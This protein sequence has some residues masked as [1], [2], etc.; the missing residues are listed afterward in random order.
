M[1]SNSVDIANLRRTIGNLDQLRS[2]Q[3]DV[4]RDLSLL[5]NVEDQEEVLQELVL[6]ALENRTAFNGY[7]SVLDGLVRRVG[8][9]PYLD[10]NL[11]GTPDKIAYE[12]HRAPTEEEPESALV[13]HREQADVL[14][15]LLV[16]NNVVLSAPTS[17]GKSLIVDA[18][19][20]SGRY[21]NVLIVVPTIAL[22]D[23][24]RRRLSR[25]FRRDYKVVTHLF[26][27]AGK[28][29]LFV[30]TQERAIERLPEG[31]DLLVIDEFYKLSPS[32]NAEDTRWNLL[33]QV[34][35][36]YVK[37]KTQFYL[38][39]PSVK[40]LSAPSTVAL[41]FQTIHTRYQTVVS[42]IHRLRG[43]GRDL[44]PLLN[45][46]RQLNDPT[47]IFCR[48]PNRAADVATALVESGIAFPSDL[49]SQA[50]EWLGENYHP[51]WHVA[52]SLQNGIGVHH[53][54]IPRAIAQFV[55]RA[56]NEDALRYLICTSTLIEGV[57]TKARNIIILD[58]TINRAPI[59]FFTFNN[60]RG[61]S[62]RMGTGHFVGNVFT[63]YEPPQDDLPLVDVPAF[64][65]TE[66]TPDSL[67]VQLDEDDLTPQSR[68]RVSRIKASNLLSYE[69][70]RANNGIEPAKQFA[71]AKD[72]AENL[73]R[74]APLLGWRQYPTTL[75]LQAMCNIFWTFF[76]GARLARGSVRSAR[77]LAFLV[78]RL[79]SKPT[80]KEMIRSQAAYEGNIDLAVQQ[81][82]DFLR[83]WAGFHFP[84]LLRVVGRIQQE[85]LGRRNLRVG[86]YGFFASQV[87]SLFLDPTML[88]LEEYGLPLELVRKLERQLIPRGDLDAVL[89]RLLTIKTEALN[90]SAF[91]LRLLSDTQQTL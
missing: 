37:R 91:E 71:F 89:Q 51:D 21:R 78:G 77:Q 33:N 75:Q 42:D 26:Q 73:L 80:A 19:I 35:Y 63:F 6:R 43:G 57:N 1:P 7:E 50:A 61:R 40:G 27:N 14:R 47:I 59:D 34:F 17:F 25:K 10:E 60:I 69:T 84:Q 18:L 79:R 66:D 58:N 65:Q 23:E 16:G 64:M 88:A 53:A 55:V 44:S 48:S 38:L 15:S 72:L 81:V 28:R 86:D 13:F 45:L 87:E 62:G 70:I 83:L 20:A 12:L 30:L 56:F 68:R 82:L 9:Y 46:C 32:Q 8:L 31:I 52:K 39:G 4:V 85:V 49:A 67:L 2:H 11:L 22:I 41:R 36:R 5:A 54:R 29:N 74:Y 90:L 76:D 24:T 3:F